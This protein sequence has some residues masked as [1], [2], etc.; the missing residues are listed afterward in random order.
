MTVTI[1]RATSAD[2]HRMAQLNGPIQA[3][4]AQARPETYKPA[5][6]T[7]ELVAHYE[8]QLS[9]PDVAVFIAEADGAPVGHAVAMIVDQPETPFNY[10]FRYL[11]L[12]EITVNPEAQR[13]GVGTALVAEVTALAR[14]HGIDIVRLQVFDWNRQALA[15]YAR[16]G[17]HTVVHRQELDLSTAEDVDAMG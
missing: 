1:R 7:P 12:D 10:A 13:R 2:A 3:L 5:Q 15:F 8:A 14:Q 6:L 4:H 11:S 16:L 17:F 9:R